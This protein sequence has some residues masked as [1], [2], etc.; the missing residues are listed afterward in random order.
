MPIARQRADDAGETDGQDEPAER[1]LSVCEDAACDE[2]GWNASDVELDQV[3][4]PH[5]GEI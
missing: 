3:L 4:I 5:D 2:L 1:K